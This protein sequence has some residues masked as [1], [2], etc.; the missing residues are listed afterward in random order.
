MISFNDLWDAFWIIPGFNFG[1][2]IFATLINKNPERWITRGEIV[3]F[4]TVIYHSVWRAE[5]L[6]KLLFL[7]NRFQSEVD[8]WGPFIFIHEV[9]WFKSPTSHS[10]FWSSERAVREDKQREGYKSPLV[11][12]D[13]GRGEV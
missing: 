4:I 10:S 8:N 2:K 5:P 7:A 3:F 1:D 9:T 13:S 12:S 11:L 6:C